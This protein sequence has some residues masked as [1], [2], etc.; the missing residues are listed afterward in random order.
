MEEG[1]STQSVLTAFVSTA[2]KHSKDRSQ[3]RHQFSPSP[4]PLFS[5]SSS[6]ASST[7]T[8]Y[9]DISEDE[10]DREVAAITGAAKA[11]EDETPSFP[12]HSGLTPPPKKRRVKKSTEGVPT[13]RTLQEEIPWTSPAPVDLP[14]PPKRRRT[15][16]PD[17]HS[18]LATPDIILP[19]PSQPQ[20]LS[21]RGLRGAGKRINP[22][23]PR[24]VNKTVPAQAKVRD[25]ETPRNIPLDNQNGAA[26]VLHD[27]SRDTS[28]AS[29]AAS[30]NSTILY[31]DTG[32]APSQA[33]S[34]RAASVAPS[35]AAST[36]PSR[37]STRA[38]SVHTPASAFR[39]ASG[40]P[41]AA[42]APPP[43]PG[44]STPT[45][46]TNQAKVF[47]S[48]LEAL[49][50]PEKAPLDA[51]G[52]EV[53]TNVKKL[54]DAIYQYPI[55][56]DGTAELY[57]SLPRPSNLEV[58]HKT[59]VNQELL[60]VMGEKA[61][62]RDT[63]LSSIQWALQFAARPQ[64]KLL[65]LLDSGAQLQPAQVVDQL[66]QTLKLLAKASVKINN[67][68]RTNIRYNVKGPANALTR[69]GTDQ[70]F[71]LLLGENFREE[72]TSRKKLAE[73]LQDVVVPHTQQRGRGNQSGRGNSRRGS[74]RSRGKNNG[75]SRQSHNNH[76]QNN[77]HNNN[78]PN[79]NNQR[80][81]GGNQRG[82]GGRGRGQGR[83]T[84]RGG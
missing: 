81:R 51:V 71:A 34:S 42:G 53:A 79:N 6:D 74:S 55:A 57:D 33:A 26:H 12:L 36:A 10:A 38:Q 17:N 67:L 83:Q 4:T 27:H 47:V 19:G 22:N 84:S 37:V 23:D 41:A 35:R 40:T 58:L 11:Q 59:R 80:G 50:L 82:R 15:T 75:Q 29:S 24:L 7:A 48:P 13:P 66:V 31:G 39:P 63:S 43:T 60:E 62:A 3:G 69:E 16:S 45:Q 18:H 20:L 14:P 25:G 54:I 8:V 70:G 61:I 44:P 30:T 5:P 21:P 64:V 72:V 1:T 76:H 77:P 9:E 73:T 32:R 68:R 2:E 65:E 52:P 46:V 78:N 56:K 28:R 49:V